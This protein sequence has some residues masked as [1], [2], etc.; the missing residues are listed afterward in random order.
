MEC[1]EDLLDWAVRASMGC[2]KTPKPISERAASE[3][4]YIVLGFRPS[5]AY[6]PAGL[7]V[8]YIWRGGG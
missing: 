8:T 3:K 5:T 6:E 4:M 1:K 7:K 2:V